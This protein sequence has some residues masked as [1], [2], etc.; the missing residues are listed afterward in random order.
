MLYP[1][2]AFFFPSQNKT[3]PAVDM[4]ILVLQ[5]EH[6]SLFEEDAEV[7]VLE[8]N[9]QLSQDLAGRPTIRIQLQHNLAGNWALRLREERNYTLKKLQNLVNLYQPE[10]GKIWTLQVLNQVGGQR[11]SWARHIYW[12][13]NILLRYRV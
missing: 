12:C 8:D 4:F 7:F 11:C 9:M 13:G 6:A 5:S 2:N 1:Q 3:R 10:L